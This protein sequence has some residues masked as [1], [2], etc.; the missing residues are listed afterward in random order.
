MGL[1]TLR[2]DSPAWSVC[3]VPDNN[4]FYGIFS[5]LETYDWELTP[6]YVPNSEFLTMVISKSFGILKPFK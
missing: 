1:E 5:I 4:T 3:Y 6:L 2:V